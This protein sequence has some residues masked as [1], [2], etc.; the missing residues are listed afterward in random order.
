MQHTATHC[1]TLQHTVPHCNTLHHPGPAKPGERFAAPHGPANI[2]HREDLIA[3]HCNTLQHT[4][5]RCN[6][7]H[8][9]AT[10]CNTLQHT[11]GP[12]KPGGRFAA[13]HGPANIKHREDL[14]HHGRAL[15]GDVRYSCAAANRERRA[16]CCAR[17]PVVCCTV[18]HG[19]GWLR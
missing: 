15:G 14:C 2:K 9:T 10:H 17:Q 11:A 12:A 7:L 18:L 3:T 16:H 4:A 1:T 8:H 19:M 13:P 6:T 5:T